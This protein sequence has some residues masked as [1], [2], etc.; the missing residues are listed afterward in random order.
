MILSFPARRVFFYYSELAH[1]EQ[2]CS[3]QPVFKM[4]AK[5]RHCF[6]KK[7]ILRLTGLRFRIIVV[8]TDNNT[9]KRKMMWQFADPAELQNVYGHSAGKA[10]LPFFIVDPV[11]LLKFIR[12]NLLNQNNFGNCFAFSIF[13]SVAPGAAVAP[14]QVHSFVGRHAKITASQD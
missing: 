6:L 10:R 14:L 11:H 1:I 5:Q 4:D 13:K 7:L 3:S 8:I 9:V 2:R 12:N